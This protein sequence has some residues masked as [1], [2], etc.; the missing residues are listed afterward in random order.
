[1][2]KGF[3]AEEDLVAAAQAGDSQALEELIALHQERV[4]RFGVKMCRDPEDAKDVLQ[5]T[6]I[7]MARSIQQFRGGSSL[8]TW[9]YTIAR[10]FCA[11]KRRRSKF[12]PAEVAPLEAARAIE[13]RAPG[14]DDI[15]EMREISDALGTAIAA[16]DPDQREVLILRDVEGLR[17]AEV[18]EALDISVAAVKSRLHRARL[19]VRKAIMPLLAPPKAS[20]PDVLMMYSK[21]LEGEISSDVCAEMEKHLEACDRCRDACDSLKETL[22]FCRSSR[23]VAVPSEVQASVRTALRAFLASTES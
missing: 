7:A 12:A 22:S 2:A 9:L 15:A 10:S 5:D 6:L 21:H 1:M 17:A 14:P 11:K 19:K 16:L 3:A 4:Y 8:S 13:S 20:C 23:A 18:S